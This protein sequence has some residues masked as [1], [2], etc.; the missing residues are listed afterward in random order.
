MPTFV[1]TKM[2]IKIA[3][4]S[5]LGGQAGCLTYFW[6]KMLNYIFYKLKSENT[7]N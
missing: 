7:E 3:G 4:A 5:H 1:G 6:N 2:D